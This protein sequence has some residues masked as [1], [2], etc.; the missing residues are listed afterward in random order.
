MECIIHFPSVTQSK[1]VSR[2]TTITLNK[3]KDI[4]KKWSSLEGYHANEVAH[5]FSKKVGG[6]LYRD[7]EPPSKAGF[8]YHV[9]CYRRFVNKSQVNAIIKKKS[10]REKEENKTCRPRRIVTTDNNFSNICIICRSKS[11]RVK[12]SGKWQH[13]KLVSCQTSDGGEN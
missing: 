8:G 5:N 6:D 10:R 1:K 13:D 9:Q 2:F 7:I 4:T 12:T 3:C 11:K